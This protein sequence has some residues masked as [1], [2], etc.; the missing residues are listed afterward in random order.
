MSHYVI[1][2][3]WCRIR[4]QP[5]PP[6]RLSSQ[7]GRVV[8]LLFLATLC[9]GIEAQSKANPLNITNRNGQDDQPAWSP[10]GSKIAF[11]SNRDGGAKGVYIMNPDG[12]DVVRV[13]GVDYLASEPTW[14]PDG[15]RIAFMWHESDQ[16]FDIHAIN[17]DGSSETIV[18]ESR[19]FVDQHPAWS[20]LG[21]KIAFV[22]K[23]DA[24]THIYSVDPS[25][26]NEARLTLD[27]PSWH[28]EWSPDGTQIAFA[29]IRDGSREILILDVATGNEIN[30][31]NH[32]GTDTDPSW[33]PDGTKIVFG[34]ERDGWSDLYMME[35]DGKNVV[36][37]TAKK[38]PTD[39]DPI[40][41][42]ISSFSISPYQRLQSNRR[43]G[44]RQRED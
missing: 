3:C 27:E 41:Q 18:E 6:V 13:T 37:L 16:G 15:K 11:V 4:N 22:S 20:P 24:M 39:Q 28:P 14:S 33:S 29:G 43:H 2:C 34:S 1:D 31:T 30:L 7:L 8:L 23:R 42:Q 5:R 35:A 9:G 32:P 40:N 19:A 44:Q 26:E 38:S 36:R 12:S 10:D 25:G 17:V 21:D